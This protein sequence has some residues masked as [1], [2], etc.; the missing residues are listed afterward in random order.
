M[1]STNASPLFPVRLSRPSP[2]VYIVLR[3]II[4]SSACFNILQLAKA[5]KAGK[6]E[7]DLKNKNLTLHSGHPI[8]KSAWRGRLESPS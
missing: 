4:S 5:G 3:T 1:Q 7:E 8:P 6:T 2:R